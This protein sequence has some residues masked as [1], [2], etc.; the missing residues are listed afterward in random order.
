M[1]SFIGESMMKSSRW[2]AVLLHVWS[3]LTPWGALYL[4][5]WIV[6]IMSAAIPASA[7]DARPNRIHI[8]YVPPKSP[9]NQR[10]Y[11]ALKEQHALEK[12]QEMFGPFRLSNDLNL[13]T[14]ECGIVNAWYQ[15][16]TVTICYEYLADILTRMPK[17]TPSG[18]TPTDAMLGQF[19]YVVAHEMGHAMF[20]FL[21]VPLF[22]RPEDA[23]DYFAAYTMLLFGKQ[24]ARRLIIGAAYTYRNA[25]QNPKVT[26]RLL[27]FSSQ[28]GAPAQRFFNLMCLAF[29]ADR[30]TFGD[31]IKIGYLPEAR[32]R[33]CRVEFGELNFAFRQLIQ[34]HVDLELARAVLQQSWLPTAEA[35]PDPPPPPPHMGQ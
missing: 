20:D 15:R 13:R 21:N 9:E 3:R 23:A 32:S 27:A 6:L 12:M 18:I 26:A 35:R 34:P 24:D 22:G 4:A 5:L 14:F 16:P 19:F 29:G 17:D 2:S 8:E 10:I 1:A 31:L 30:E 28:H 25:I 7:D 33:G 11:E